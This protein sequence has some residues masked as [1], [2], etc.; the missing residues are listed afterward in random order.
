MSTTK[1]SL[2]H[3]QEYKNTINQ[4]LLAKG[5]KDFSKYEISI[6]EDN[7]HYSRWEYPNID[8]LEQFTPIT[9]NPKYMDLLARAIVLDIRGIWNNIITNTSLDDMRRRLETPLYINMYGDLVDENYRDEYVIYHI[10]N[11]HVQKPNFR[12]DWVVLNDTDTLGGIIV[13]G[14]NSINFVKDRPNCTGLLRFHFFYF[15]RNH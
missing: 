1:C 7:V 15:H 11:F 5:I 9:V 4:Y 3:L 14:L 2:K 8:R 10:E 12:W 13:M 6:K